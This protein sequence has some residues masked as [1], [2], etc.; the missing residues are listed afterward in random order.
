MVFTRRASSRV[1][2][3]TLAVMNVYAYRLDAR[4]MAPLVEDL[5]AVQE[6]LRSQ[7]ILFAERL[8]RIGGPPE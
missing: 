6:E 3:S 4:Q 2:S 1:V 8:E 7:L 5:T